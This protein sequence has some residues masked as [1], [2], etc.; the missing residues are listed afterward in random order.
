M[1]NL[2]ACLS[3][4]HVSVSF[5]G[6]NALSDVTMA[7]QPGAITGL[8]GPNG[9]GKT[10]LFNVITGVQRPGRGRVHLDGRDVSG[11]DVYRRSRLGMARTFQRVETFASLTVR[12][13]ILVAAEQN[14][15]WRRAGAARHAAVDGLLESTGLGAVADDVVGS[16]PTGTARIVELA[17]AMAT[18]PQLLLLDEPSSGLNEVE[19]AALKTLL[20]ELAADGLAVLLVE[21]DMP[22]VMD[23]CESV[24]V[25]NFGLLIAHGSPAAIQQHAVVRSAYLGDHPEV[26]S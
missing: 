25:L 15:R 23:C 10:T 20:L 12:D 4:D 22:F 14:R 18:T 3:V 21:H 24:Y 13:N 2:T 26:D 11:L 9:A 1:S 16:L 7:V 19:T 8:I 17:R 5:R 6:V